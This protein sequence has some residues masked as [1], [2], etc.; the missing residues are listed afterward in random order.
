MNTYGW[1]KT[2]VPG[3]LFRK[4]LDFRMSF[5]VSHSANEV[6]GVMGTKTTFNQAKNY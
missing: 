4:P 2:G 6:E 3:R 5:V 1:T